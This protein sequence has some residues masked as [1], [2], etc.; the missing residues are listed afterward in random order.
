MDESWVKI[1]RSIVDHPMFT[2]RSDAIKLWLYL[3]VSANWKPS[4]VYIGG[5]LVTIERGQ[6]LTAY[7]RLS[8]RTGI[9]LQGVRSLLQHFRR[10][11]IVSLKTNTHATVV[12]I[13]NYDTLQGHDASDQHTTNTRPTHDQHTSNTII[14]REEVKK[15]RREERNNTLGE[16]GTRA[17]SRT[18]HPSL[19]EVREYFVSQGSTAIE[20][21][22]FH[23]HFTSNGW[24]VGGKAP[25]RD[26]KA[27][28]RNWLRRSN[29]AGIPKANPEITARTKPVGMPQ[30][31]VALYAKAV[32]TDEERERIKKL[33]IEKD[34]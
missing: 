1:P 26:W 8:E 13:I 32:A 34:A 27:A 25:M 6:V 10:T 17:L 12:T 23:D 15:L 28:C 22:G 18:P 5:E 19:D 24:K 11:Q 2:M 20:A 16:E 7:R 14:R 21:Q 4:Q 33:F 30:Q 31:V 3:L 29:A 9:T